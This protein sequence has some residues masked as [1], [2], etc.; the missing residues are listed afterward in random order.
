MKGY[1][2]RLVIAFVVLGLAYYFFVYQ[3]ETPA[4]ATDEKIWASKVEAMAQMKTNLGAIADAER[5]A[6]TLSGA[7]IECAPNPPAIPERKASWD[8]GAATGWEE[9]GITMPRETWFQYEVVVTGEDGFTIYARTLA[10]GVLLEYTMD[11][12]N[13]LSQ[14]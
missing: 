2:W 4:P 12:D 13:N 5:G 10:E 8:A 7:F 3:R 1:G 9:L 6:K 14:N 11:Q